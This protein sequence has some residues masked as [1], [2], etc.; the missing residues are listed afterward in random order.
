MVKYVV[1]HF[2]V[3]TGVILN[4][5]GAIL[6]YIS[7]LDS[8]VCSH[9]YNNSGYM[10]AIIGQILTACAQ[11]FFLYAPTKLANTWFGPDERALCT[12]LASMG[13]YSTCIVVTIL[14]IFNHLYANS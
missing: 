13:K 1:F 10:V 9:L 6:R 2:Q 11:P 14:Q 3:F 8:I 5:T 12:V 4:L 7:T